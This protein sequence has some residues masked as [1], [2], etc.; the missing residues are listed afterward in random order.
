MSSGEQGARI[1]DVGY[2]AYDGPRSPP[3]WALATVW[4][5]T[6][7]RVL[8]LHR[9]FRHKVLPGIALVVA[10]FPALIYVGIAA[11]LPA[12]R[13][14]N[15]ILPSYGD[16][17]GVITM[18]LALFASLVAPEALCTDRRTGMLDL[19]LAGPLDVKRYLA[20]KWAAVAGVM[21]VM[22][23]G[24]QLFLLVSYSI[25]RAGPSL[26]EAPPL[27]LRIVVSGTGVA[28]FYTAVAMG[29]ASL[30]TRRAVAAVAT[31]L[32]LLVPTIAV[33][34]AVESGGAPDELALLAPGVATEYAWR[35]F[36][37][38]RGP[39][40]GEP[41]IAGVSTGLVL[42]GLVGWIALGAVVCLVSYRRQGARR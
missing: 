13:V 23:V 9:P 16:Y 12:G 7:Q 32:I 39:S 11:Y 22:T 5:H 40:D 4:R 1:F 24:P 25:V 28:L 6:V 3:A 20:A 42:A 14:L 19:Y 37:E 17:L 21:S 30:T 10:F 27:L 36:G 29:V 35:V 34:V 41:A 8:G 38:T 15:D 31:V 2:R 26:G 18:A 33:G